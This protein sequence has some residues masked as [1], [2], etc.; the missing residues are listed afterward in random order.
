MS[1]KRGVICES[2][3]LATL[4]NVSILVKFLILSYNIFLKDAILLDSLV[5]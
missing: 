5:V 3:S 2:I 4:K 1:D